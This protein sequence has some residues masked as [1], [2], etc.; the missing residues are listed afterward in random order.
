MSEQEEEK[1]ETQIGSILKARQADYPQL[2]CDTKI[3]GD[4]AIALLCKIQDTTKLFEI[5]SFFVQVKFAD[6]KNSMVFGNIAALN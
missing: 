1:R 4:F 3:T 6:N 2:N 5:C